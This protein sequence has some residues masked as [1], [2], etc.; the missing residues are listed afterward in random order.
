MLIAQN[1]SK[2]V[3]FFLNPPEYS[4]GT[5]HDT[6]TNIDKT[7]IKVE[8]VHREITEARPK[9][10]PGFSKY[11]KLIMCNGLFFKLYNNRF[12]HF[13]HIGPTNDTIVLKSGVC[14]IDVNSW[15]QSI[16][17]VFLPVS[18]PQSEHQQGSFLRHA[19]HQEA[20]DSK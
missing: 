10:V 9:I 16:A 4:A 3:D 1:Q 7:Q 6:L 2:W 14:R 8:L 13:W 19:G 18:F 11:Q 17:D 20:E 15:K 12:E 5:R